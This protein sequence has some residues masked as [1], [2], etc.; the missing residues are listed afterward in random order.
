MIKERSDGI[1][2]AYTKID[3]DR[4]I[5]EQLKGEYQKKFLMLKLRL[6]GGYRKP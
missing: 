2:N 1:K 6:P 4:V 3:D 5:A